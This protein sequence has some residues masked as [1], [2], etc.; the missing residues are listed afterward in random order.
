MKNKNRK[1]T[2]KLKIPIF[3]VS[4]SVFAGKNSSARLENANFEP[5][6]FELQ[7]DEAVAVS[8][9]KKLRHFAIALPE[10]VSHST[11][12]HEISHIVDFILIRLE[13]TVVNEHTTE[14]RAHLH[15]YIDKKIR[16]KLIQHLIPLK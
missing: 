6:D 3:F 12:S 11:L 9:T 2:I 15:D 7:N 16:S 4:L 8:H 1:T 5:I 10:K 14:V 13:C